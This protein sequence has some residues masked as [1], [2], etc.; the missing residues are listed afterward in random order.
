VSKHGQY[1]KLLFVDIGIVGTINSCIPEY[2]HIDISWNIHWRTFDT[3]CSADSWNP[4]KWVLHNSIT[5]FENTQS[6][7]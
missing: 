2:L 3:C 7:L 5:V 6:H 4:W 1:L